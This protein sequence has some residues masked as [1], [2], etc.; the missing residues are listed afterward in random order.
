MWIVATLV[1]KWGP[2][3]KRDRAWQQIFAAFDSSRKKKQ[4]KNKVKIG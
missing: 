1:Q 3:T 2:K 4:L